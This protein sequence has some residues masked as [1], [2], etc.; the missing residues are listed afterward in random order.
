MCKSFYIN[1]LNVVNGFLNL[2]RTKVATG[3]GFTRGTLIIKGITPDRPRPPGSSG[4]RQPPALR[5]DSQIQ[6]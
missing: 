5:F 2:E 6:V 4:S 1:Y 3:H